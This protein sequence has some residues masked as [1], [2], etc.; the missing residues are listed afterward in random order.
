MDYKDK[1]LKYKSKYLVLKNQL[2]SA[3]VSRFDSS[4]GIIQTKFNKI[5]L[6]CLLFDFY[7]ELNQLEDKNLDEK[8][9]IFIKYSLEIIENFR[10]DT[11]GSDAAKMEI[12]YYSTNPSRRYPHFSAKNTRTSGKKYHY[13]KSVDCNTQRKANN[14]DIMEEINRMVG[15]EKY[16]FLKIYQLMESN[17]QTRFLSKKACIFLFLIIHKDELNF[18]Y[19]YF[20]DFFR[21]YELSQIIY[22]LSKLEEYESIS[23][24]DKKKQKDDFNK[25][26]H[27]QIRLSEHIHFDYN[28]F[29]TIILPFFKDKNELRYFLEPTKTEPINSF[30]ERFFNQPNTVVH[31]VNLYGVL[32]SLRVDDGSVASEQTLE[33][34]LSSTSLK[35]GSADSSQ[36][37]EGVH[38]KAEINTCNTKNFTTSPNDGTDGTTATNQCMLIS[39]LHYL[40]NKGK[41]RSAI[42]ILRFRGEILKIKKK[43]WSENE[44]FDSIKGAR[45]INILRKITSKYKINLRIH[46]VVNDNG[47]C[48]LGPEIPIQWTEEVNN[49][50]ESILV[51]HTLED[52]ENA[53][54]VKIVQTRDPDHFELLLS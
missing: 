36:K 4:K 26:I 1:Y 38:E 5:L 10:F 51:P 18:L 44:D 54:T 7:F 22:I 34:D 48:T 30:K 24:A 45:Q 14:I 50:T 21:Y 12:I 35:K 53:H 6:L 11:T 41:I 52:I 42:D 46:K 33:G 37:L 15:I 9:R 19:S 27:D 3:N 13:S 39:I 43:E 25:K 40:K 31:L 8:N 49:G 29:L 28:E 47:N 23:G 2:G 20:K 16:V 32:S 17:I